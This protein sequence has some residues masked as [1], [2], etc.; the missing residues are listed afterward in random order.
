MGKNTPENRPA[1]GNNSKLYGKIRAKFRPDS[2][3]A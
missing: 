1:S 3:A 2:H